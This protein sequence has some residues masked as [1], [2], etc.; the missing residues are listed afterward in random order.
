MPEPGGGPDRGVLKAPRGPCSRSQAVHVSA[1]GRAAD[2][3]PLSEQPTHRTT[4]VRRATRCRYVRMRRAGILSFGRVIRRCSSVRLRP[5][6][7]SR[8]RGQHLRRQGGSSVPVAESL[9]SRPVSAKCLSPDQLLL[10]ALW[11]TLRAWSGARKSSSCRRWPRL[12]QRRSP[13]PAQVA[14]VGDW[15]PVWSRASRV[16]S[17]ADGPRLPPGHSALNRRHRRR[18][19]HSVVQDHL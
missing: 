17:P 6:A 12:R 15:R 14:L 13:P 11:T 10:P 7:S 8:S 4:W 1:P 16:R 2:S 18:C 9:R 5:A 3:T 19:R